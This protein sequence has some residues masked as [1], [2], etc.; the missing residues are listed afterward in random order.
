MVSNG[1]YK[2]SVASHEAGLRLDMLLADHLPE[3]SRSYAALLIRQAQVR[4]DG[5]TQ[6]PSYKV[7]LNQTIEG[8]IPEPKGVDL[9]AEP[10][11]L[12]VLFEDSQ[13]IVVNK[14]PAMVVHPA[15]GHANGTLV[16]ALL[17]HCP[18]LTG[19]GG[20][21]RPGIVHRLDR[22][23]SGVMVVAKTAR[24]HHELSRQFKTRTTEKRYLAL[25]H[26]IPQA[27]HGCIDLPVGRH[28][29]DRK[30][31]S[32]ISP[33]GRKACT[34][35]RIIEKFRESALLE[36]DLK[37]GRTHQI[38]VHC[39]AIGHPVVGDPVYGPSKGLQRVAKN[40]S[41]LYNV[42][43]SAK[44][45]MLHALQLALDHPVSGP[46]LTFNAPLPEDMALVLKSLRGIT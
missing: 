42:L 13:L 20:E 9:V 18:D 23:T 2:F 19:I 25:V 8:R 46:R 5:S 36:I 17:H 7:K 41:V 31:M 21:L 4:V 45:Q 26:G 38:R 35:W 30:K 11:A 39:K 10:I 27:Q 29:S 15:A 40:D 28:P 34:L 1:V 22:D 3:C 24:A 44:R 6:K 32:T 33:S 12:D 16:N 14:P 43:K 37:T